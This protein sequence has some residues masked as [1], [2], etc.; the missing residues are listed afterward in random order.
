MIKGNF[1]RD[2]D[3]HLVQFTLTGHADSGPY[4][5]DLVCAAVSA[6]AISTVNG[7]EALAG[8]TPEV[9]SDNQNGGYL[10]M[11]L[12]SGMSGEQVNISQILL[13]NLLLGLQSV[14]AE[15]QKYLT[16]QTINE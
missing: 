4:G 9:I 8:F 1:K 10:S 12:I 16:V 6:L 15:N 7:L 11:S 13:E 2:A 3:G 5:S 14:A